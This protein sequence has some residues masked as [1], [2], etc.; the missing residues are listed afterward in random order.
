MIGAFQC[1]PG[2]LAGSIRI[3]THAGNASLVGGLGELLD[4]KKRFA[5]V[6]HYERVGI[7]SA[8]WCLEPV[9]SGRL[10]CGLDSF[11]LR[12]SSDSNAPDCPSVVLSDAVTD[13]HG[14]LQPQRG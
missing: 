13:L 14:G 12:S 11:E 7:V 2:R 4:E 10:P 3:K 1:D 6:Q 8:R 9:Q 5:V